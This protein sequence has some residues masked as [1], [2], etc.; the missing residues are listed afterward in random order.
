[1]F[2]RGDCTDSHPCWYRIYNRFSGSVEHAKVYV[3]ILS[4]APAEARASAV[5]PERSAALQ[6]SPPPA[7]PPR[8]MRPPDRF[9][10]HAVQKE[11]RAVQPVRDRAAP[12]DNLQ[13]A[14][15]ASP[16]G[17]PGTL[18]P[19]GTPRMVVETGGHAAMIRELLFTAD[20]R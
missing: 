10:S 4:T 18:W 11:R 5:A 7:A 13:R 1:M 20:G 12:P 3:H 8:S 15:Q 6:E 9:N 16:V 14:A 2:I 17:E 19:E